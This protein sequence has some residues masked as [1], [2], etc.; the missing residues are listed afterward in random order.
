MSILHPQTKTEEKAGF[1]IIEVMLVLGVSGLLLIGVLTGTYS[2]IAG[3]RYNDSVRSFSELLRQVYSE[4]ISP[5]SLGSGNS[6]DAA[7][8]GKAIFFGVDDEKTLYTATLVGDPVTSMNSQGFIAE[9]GKVKTELFCGSDDDATTVEAKVPAWEAQINAPDGSLF[10]GTVL[11][12]RSPASGTVY[13]AY[14]PWVPSSDPSE[15]CDSVSTSLA[16][17]IKNTGSGLSTDQDFVPNQDLHFCIKSENSNIVRNVELTAD[18]HNTSAV[19][20]LTESENADLPD[21]ERCS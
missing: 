2:S 3:Q 14:S 20:I 13:T 18:G 7:I 10:R 9:L 12:A 17:T 15:N 4:V 5:E 21:E 11:I 1:T 6:D 16:E 8:Y 19:R